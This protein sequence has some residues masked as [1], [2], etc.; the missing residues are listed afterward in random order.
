MTTVVELEIP[1][2][3]L[4]LAR[5]FDRVPAFEFRI[6]GVIGDSPPIV[7]TTGPD[8]HTVAQ[9]L[10]ADPSVE[11]VA[12]LRGKLRSGPGDETDAEHYL[13]RLA[14]DD[15]IKLFEQLVSEPGGAVLTAR[16]RDGTWTMQ[17][18]FHDRE[19]VSTCH[20][21]LETYDFGVE[22][23]RVTGIDG[24]DRSRTPLTETQYETICTAHELGY[25]DV[26]R[27]ITL[28]E[29]AA[30]LGVSHQALSERLRRGHAALI[31]AEL[32]DGLSP[33]AIDP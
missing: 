14:F 12:N 22:V 10:E 25:F 5:T 9:A 16:G 23:R 28:E 21:L 19:A 29:L 1:A 2:D 18:L 15:G 3:R 31:S 6:G 30:E 7:S 26:P 11:V 33:A 20:E 32:T 27:G 24:L 13:F 17:L 8:R 4:G